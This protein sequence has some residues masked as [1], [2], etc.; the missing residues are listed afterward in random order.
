VASD[1][2][3][4]VP[5]TGVSGERICSPGWKATTLF[6]GVESDDRLYAL[7]KGMASAMP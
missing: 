1:E 4:I 6:A 5:K 2:W 7:L 3:D